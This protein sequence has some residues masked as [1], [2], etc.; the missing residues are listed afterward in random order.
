MG[1]S[2]PLLGVEME[3]ERCG[4]PS[5]LSACT[6]PCAAESLMPLWEFRE[7]FAPLGRLGVSRIP[8]VMSLFVECQEGPEK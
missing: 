1:M 8:K 5:E 2:G 4:F 3:S 6:E 7:S